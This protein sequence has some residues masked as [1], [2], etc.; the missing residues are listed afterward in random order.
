MSITT[1]MLHELFYYKDGKLFNRVNRGCSKEGTEA[2]YNV[3]RGYR[4]VGINGRRYSVHRIIYILHHGHI[5]NKLVID[6]IDRDPTNNHID[7]LR[8]VTIKENRYNSNA[9][10]C[11]YDKP[12]KKWRA[13]IDVAEKRI[14]LGY[15]ESEQ[16]AHQAYLDAKKVYHIIKEAR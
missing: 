15:Y 2:G 9:R 11:W 12:S 14:Y 5:P 10:G 4:Q 1:D 16:E 6:H 7:N 3:S 13:C 8:A